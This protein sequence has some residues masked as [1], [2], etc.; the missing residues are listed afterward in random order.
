VAPMRCNARFRGRWKGVLK[1]KYLPEESRKSPT[2]M[3]KCL[4]MG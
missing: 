4:A 1:E 2:V 3:M